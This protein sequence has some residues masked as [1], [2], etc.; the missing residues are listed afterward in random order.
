MLQ[1]I[2][3]FIFRNLTPMSIRYLPA[4]D[5][6]GATG[7]PAEVYRQLEREFQTVPPITM[8]HPDPGLMA[9]VWSACRETLVAGPDRSLKEAVAVAV[10]E[11]NRCPYCIQ[12]HTSFFE[13]SGGE[14]GGY[15]EVIAWAAATGR[16]MGCPEVPKLPQASVPAVLGTAVVFHYINRMVNIFL[17]DSMMPV[18]GKMPLLGDQALRVFSSVVSGRIATIAV[19]PGEFLTPEPDLTLPDAFSWAKADRLVAGGLLRFTEAARRAGALI[20]PEVQDIVTQQVA[21][22]NGD[23]PGL[24]KA[25]LD[26]LVGVLPERHRPQARIALLAA[27]ASW[28][29]DAGEIAAFRKTGGDDRALLDTAA[30]GAFLAAERVAGWMAA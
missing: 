20:V 8:H 7:L 13:G 21:M 17:D 23:V 24:G 12:A 25:W 15:R 10:S 22:W 18:I 27:M 3:Q 28:T 14:A 5:V 26:Q 19:K 1:S 11:S 29:V 6:A 4:P 2:E 9:G 16:R 30:W